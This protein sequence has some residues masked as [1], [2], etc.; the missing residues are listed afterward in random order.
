MYRDFLEVRQAPGDGWFVLDATGEQSGVYLSK[1][2]AVE[3]AKSAAKSVGELMG[4]S[5]RVDVAAWKH[6]P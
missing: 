2:D 5:V 3:H 6:W 4:H 1:F